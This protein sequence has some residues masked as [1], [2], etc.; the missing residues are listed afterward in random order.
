MKPG[1]A[2]ASHSSR[3][4]VVVRS[5]GESTVSG[6]TVPVLFTVEEEKEGVEDML[7]KLNAVMPVLR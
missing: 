5:E 3:G 7:L 1:A 6:G 2:A 4:T